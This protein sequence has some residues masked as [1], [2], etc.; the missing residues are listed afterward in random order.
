MVTFDHR[1]PGTPEQKW[2][3][4]KALRTAPELD[5]EGVDRAVV[6]AAHPDDETLGA[7]GTVHRLNQAGSSVRVIVAT[8]SSRS[9]SSSS[10]CVVGMPV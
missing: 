6:F 3:D 10:S 7:G 1:E 4:S 2:A 9:R 5:L 8:W